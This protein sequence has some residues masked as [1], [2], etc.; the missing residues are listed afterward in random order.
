MGLLDNKVCIIT[1]G[2]GSLGLA[3]A[4]QFIAEGAKVLIVDLKEADLERAKAELK[5][6]N[7]ELSLIHI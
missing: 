4:R 1:G 5:S 7:V 6:P 3:S 2:A